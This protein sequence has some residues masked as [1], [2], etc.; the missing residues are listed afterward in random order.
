[1]TLRVPTFEPE[2]IQAAAR[3]WGGSAE[4][5]ATTALRITTHRGVDLQSRYGK[6]DE[7]QTMADMV[8]ALPEHVAWAVSSIAYDSKAG[9]IAVAAECG[10]L[11]VEMLAREIRAAFLAG[12]GSHPAISIRG[13]CGAEV[14][15]DPRPGQ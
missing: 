12:Y 7:V 6:A 8:D 4:K 13:L 2:V 11:G 9:T 10:P 14:S 5:I 3:R 15:L 1:M